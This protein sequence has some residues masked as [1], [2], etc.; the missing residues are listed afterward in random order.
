MGCGEQAWSDLEALEVVLD[1]EDP[2]MCGRLEKRFAYEGVSSSPNTSA[3]KASMV[4]DFCHASSGKAAFW[5]VCARKVSRS[6]SCSTGTCGRSRPRRLPLEIS[7]PWR[8][9]TTSLAA[10]GNKGEST[11]SENWSAPA[12]SGVTGQKRE[13]SNAAARAVSATAR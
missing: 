12:S 11:L 3:V 2:E 6:Q 9:T 4:A 13:S 10:I 7:K 1:R 8:P 5:Q